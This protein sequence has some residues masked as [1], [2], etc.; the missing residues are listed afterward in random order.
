MLTALKWMLAAIAYAGVVAFVARLV[1]AN[2]L[3]DEERGQ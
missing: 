3:D 1:G 2:H